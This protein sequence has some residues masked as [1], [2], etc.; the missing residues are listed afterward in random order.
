M[1][2]NDQIYTL[3]IVS[4]P[5]VSSTSLLQSLTRTGLPILL[6]TIVEIIGLYFNT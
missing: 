3:S 4:F 5:T 1:N 6:Y 2:T